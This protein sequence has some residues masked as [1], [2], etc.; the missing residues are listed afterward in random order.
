MFIIKN[1]ENFNSNEILEAQRYIYKLRNGGWPSTDWKG[2]T[3]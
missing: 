3:E 2:F 1:K